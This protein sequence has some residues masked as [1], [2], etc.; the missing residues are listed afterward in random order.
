V[1]GSFAMYYR[2]PRTPNGEERHLTDTATKL[3]ALAIQ[4]RASRERPM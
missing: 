2:E 3:A 4:H 1:L